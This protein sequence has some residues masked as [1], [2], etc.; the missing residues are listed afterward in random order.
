MYSQTQISLSQLLTKGRQKLGIGQIRLS[1]LLNIKLH[2]L[3]DLEKSRS[4]PSPME[5]ER[6][7]RQMLEILEEANRGQRL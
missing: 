3:S 4:F 7:R 1:K 6:L 5:E 2:R